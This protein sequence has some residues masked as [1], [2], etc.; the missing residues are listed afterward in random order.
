MFTHLAGPAEDE[1]EL[2][3][4]KSEIK[5]LRIV[6]NVQPGQSNPQIDPLRARRDQI[7]NAY[8][9]P[10]G[11]NLIDRKRLDPVFQQ[12]FAQAQAGTIFGVSPLL[13][14]GIV[15]AGVFVYSRK[16]Q[17]KKKRIKGKRVKGKKIKGKKRGKK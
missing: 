11:A 12:Q 10:L 7:L 13:I 1:Q 2:F 3:A 5:R 17:G 9:N 14:G 16:K 4:L 15:L 6:L 8:G